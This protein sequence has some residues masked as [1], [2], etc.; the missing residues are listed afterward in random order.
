MNTVSSI[1][2]RFVFSST[3][4]SVIARIIVLVYSILLLFQAIFVFIVFLV[5]IA[6]YTQ[7]QKTNPFGNYRQ[8][9][10]II[11]CWALFL[12][13][14]LLGVVGVAQRKGFLV[15]GFAILNLFFALPF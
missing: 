5:F 13:V 15:G 8:I 9:I 10:I 14:P 2:N 3:A 6:S 11:F 7:T 4:F 12:P 1:S